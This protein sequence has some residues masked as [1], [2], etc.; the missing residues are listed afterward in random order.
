MNRS[1][2]LVDSLLNGENG[3]ADRVRV[4]TDLANSGIDLEKPYLAD[5][6]SVDVFRNIGISL[7]RQARLGRGRFSKEIDGST[8]GSV[9]AALEMIS[10]NISQSA[11]R[12][13]E[14]IT[15]LIPKPSVRPFA[16]SR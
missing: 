15:W 16:R 5:V 4:L 8:I 13:G 12:W 1:T 11:I 10:K 6:N 9:S 7:R 2:V 3:V 14:R